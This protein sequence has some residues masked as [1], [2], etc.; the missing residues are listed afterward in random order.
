MEA[1]SGD[2]VVRRSS[3]SI[4]GSSPEDFTEGL[5]ANRDEALHTFGLAPYQ[6]RYW[7]NRAPVFRITLRLPFRASI[8]FE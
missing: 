3:V 2:F 8:Q 6:I 7:R 4:P 5:N 1:R